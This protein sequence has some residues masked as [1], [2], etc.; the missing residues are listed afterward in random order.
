[1]ERKTPG[2]DSEEVARLRLQFQAIEKTAIRKLF[3][4]RA[5]ILQDLPTSE[6]MGTGAGTGIQL[7]EL[8]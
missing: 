7:R 2:L 4:F 5:A 6:P 8:C 1:L 3:Q